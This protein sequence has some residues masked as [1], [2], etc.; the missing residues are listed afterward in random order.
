MPIQ[1]IEAVDASDEYCEESR[2]VDLFGYLLRKLDRITDMLGGI[3]D[4]ADL[5]NDM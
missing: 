4:S 2:L 3:H 5:R 1:L